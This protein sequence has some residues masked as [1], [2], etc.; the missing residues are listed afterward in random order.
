MLWL[1]LTLA[2]AMVWLL[3]AAIGAW[4]ITDVFKPDD[5]PASLADIT[6]LIPAR[7]EAQTLGACLHAL[8]AQGTDLRIVVVDDQSTDA[9]PQVARVALAGRGEVLAGAPLPTGW[10]GKLWALEQGRRAVKTTHV[11]LLDADIA[12]APGVVAGL[13]KKM[14]ENQL[15]LASL[16]VQLPTRCLA[17]KLLIPAFV[18]FFKLLYPFGLSNNPRYGRIAAAAGGCILLDTRA[19]DQ[20]GGFA[21]LRGAL[22]DDCTLAARIKAGGFRTW[23]GL[24]HAAHSLRGYDGFM[25]IGNM[26]AR[27]A[28]SQLRFSLLLLL[29]VTA[30]FCITFLLPPLALLLASGA[31]QWLAFVAC[32][33][34]TL[35]Y[36]PLLTHYRL[37][38]AWALL[39]PAI[40]AFYLAMTWLSAWRHWRGAGAQWK[41]R[42]YGKS[43]DSKPCPLH[44]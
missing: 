5:A 35:L 23:I 36:V 30:V 25:P 29:A 19:L 16:M 44:S 32:F 15:A 1:S 40:A 26:I 22:I 13:Q 38:P 41:G 12:L 31:A 14:R 6:V 42:A 37:S 21:S 34:M 43:M 28:F 10:A 2:G 3:I 8:A 20:I 7:N 39:M 27:S 11:L 18:F 33:A 9:T 24:T 17:E 4:R